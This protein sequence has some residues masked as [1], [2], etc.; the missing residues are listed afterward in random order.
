MKRQ[1]YL[2]DDLL[3]RAIFGIVV[4]YILYLVLEYFVNRA[5]FWKWLIYG[6]LF[7]C[8][9]TVVIFVLNDLKRRKKQNKLNNLLNEIKEIRG[10]EYIQNFIRRFGLEKKKDKIWSCRNYNFDLDRLGDFRKFLKDKG[11]RV[12]LD[13]WDDIHLLLQH[14]IQDR[15]EKLTREFISSSPQ[16]FSNLTGYDFEGLIHRLFEAMTY[17]VQQVG[18]VGDQGG[19][20][21]ANKEQERLLIQAK[22][23]STSVGNSAVQQAVAAKNHYDCN[24]AIVVT[25]SNFT[26]EAIELAR[27]NNV[28]LISKKRLQEMLLEYLKEN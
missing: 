10:E 21:I 13:K 5:N 16:K 17:S 7:C 24:K 9:L 26:R 14:F 4:L 2:E 18:K 1:S 20:L 27:T 22:C 12:S 23:W 19:D 15:E 28:E 25:T 6:L 3:E 8:I 11:L